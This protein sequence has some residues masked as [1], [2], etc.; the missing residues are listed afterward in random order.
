[1][2]TLQ[3]F[4]PAM[5]H[6]MQHYYLKPAAVKRSKRK[7]LA[8]R[9]ANAQKVIKRLHLFPALTIG[10]SAISQGSKIVYIQL[11]EFG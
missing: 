3:R 9:R 2:L 11:S 1:M 6:S 7:M 5:F 10:G 4:N 8:S